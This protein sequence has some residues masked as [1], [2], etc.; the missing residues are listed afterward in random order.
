MLVLGSKS[1]HVIAPSPPRSP[2]PFPLYRRSEEEKLTRE[3]RYEKL[4]KEI[5]ANKTARLDIQSLPYLRGVIREGLRLSM[6][7]PTRLPR[8]VPP[9]GFTYPPYSIPAGTNVGVAAYELHL[10]PAVFS[11]PEEF[12]PER[13]VDASEEMARDW[14]PF[15]MGSRACIARNLAT[16]ELF[17]AVERVAESGVLSGARAVGGRIEIMEWFNSKVK[18]ERIELV[19][20]G[21]T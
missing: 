9:G 13:W 5:E 8:V 6:A 19:W 16:V 15:G 12:R 7:N 3:L 14:I 20:P 17:M 1:W 11:E 18:G 21:K 4:Q 2:S 10:N